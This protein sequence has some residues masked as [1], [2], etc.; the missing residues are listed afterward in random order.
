MR[1]TSLKTVFR[2]LTLYPLLRAASKNKTRGE[3]ARNRKSQKPLKLVLLLSRT[4]DIDLLQHI[5]RRAQEHPDI[6]PELWTR[7]K[8]LKKFPATR[9]LLQK[10]DL[11]I[12]FR[13]GHGNLKS[14]LSRFSEVDALLN[15]VESSIAK[16]KVASRLVR[17][18]KAAGVRTYT[19]QHAFENI[20]LT[21][22]DPERDEEINFAADRVL[23]WGE[24]ENL[25]GNPTRETLAKCIGVGCPK[26]APYIQEKDRTPSSK[27]PLIAVFEG[28]HAK[29][30]NARYLERFFRDLQDAADRFPEYTFML[31][32][33]PSITS[34]APAHAEALRSLNN[35]TVLDP[36]EPANC[37]AWPTEKLLTTAQAVITTP[38]TI[39][40]DAALHHIPVAVTRYREQSP[41]YKRYHP[42]PLLDVRDDWH[43]FLR[44]L[45]QQPQS[46][47]EKTDSFLKLVIIPGDA[48]A[49]ILEIISNDC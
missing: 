41:N 9:E 8:I 10:Y 35:I 4:H 19:L 27:Q 24:P 13:V 33:H 15:T 34:R 32:P 18:A 38:S 31:K 28:L 39:A 23:T 14:A 36:A 44:Q 30:F 37:V 40:L 1:K 2:E 7:R 25:T 20:G 26:F 22:V 46:L 49:R 45:K 21:Y 16:H 48:A 42:L 5:Y 3:Y 47:K 43:H 17:I 12:A 11:K 6:E 29:Q